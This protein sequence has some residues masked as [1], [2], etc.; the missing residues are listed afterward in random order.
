M[1]K[2]H[3]ATRNV[4]R[5]FRYDHLPERF[6]SSSKPFAL[7]A[8]RIVEAASTEGGAEA[9]IALRKLLEAKDAAVRSTLKDD[10][11]TDEELERLLLTGSRSSE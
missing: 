9:T 7:R 2:F 10:A 4:L 11:G 8:L 6:Q 5:L 1:S 3:P